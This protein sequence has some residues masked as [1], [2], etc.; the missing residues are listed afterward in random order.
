MKKVIERIYVTKGDNLFNFEGLKCDK[1]I[2]LQIDGKI[3]WLNHTFARLNELADQLRY[4]FG[5]SI[6]CD[7]KK[8][9][10]FDEVEKDTAY[11]NK[12]VTRINHHHDDVFS[13]KSSYIKRAVRQP[14][15]G[16]YWWHFD[17]LRNFLQ[18]S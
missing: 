14:E 18:S 15:T 1:C 6:S 9:G 2:G 8:F 12:N 10:V 5:I 13:N 17:E 7:Q 11:I 4:N 3:Y 16:F